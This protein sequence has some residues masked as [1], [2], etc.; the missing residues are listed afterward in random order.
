MQDK[1]INGY[2]D[3][4][5]YLARDHSDSDRNC[6]RLILLHVI[7]FITK[8]LHNPTFII[9]TYRWRANTCKSSLSLTAFRKY[10]RISPDRFSESSLPT[11]LNSQRSTSRTLR[12]EIR[13]REAIEWLREF[14]T[15]N[16]VIIQ[17]YRVDDEESFEHSK[18]DWRSNLFLN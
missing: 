14:R 17:K 3:P 15:S 18:S 16:S 10:S 12:K 1:S 7:I 5:L 2:I 11:S 8:S 4:I 9:I 13:I 6:I